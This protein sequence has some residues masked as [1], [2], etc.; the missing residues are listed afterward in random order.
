MND[1]EC[2]GRTDEELGLV[3]GRCVCKTY[4]SGFN[5]DQCK[6]GYYNLTEENP[7]GCTGKYIVCLNIHSVAQSRCSSLFVFNFSRKGWLFH[8]KLIFVCFDV[9]LMLAFFLTN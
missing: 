1:G 9:S 5:C 2:D 4:V 3:A 6:T 8:L 7:D